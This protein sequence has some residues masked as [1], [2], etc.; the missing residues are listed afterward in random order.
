[1]FFFGSK[2]T[3]CILLSLSPHRYQVVVLTGANTQF[4]EAL[5]R[6]FYGAGCKLVLVGTNRQ[7]LERVRSQLFSLRP[8]D[9][10]VFQPEVVPMESSEL[11][12]SANEK[13][14]EILESDKKFPI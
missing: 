10:P 5:A 6:A 11:E 1:M 3:S 4:G 7:E 13:A 9:I 14:A 8:K 12:F 2:V